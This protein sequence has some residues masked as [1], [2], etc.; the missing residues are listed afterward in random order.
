[1]GATIQE[2]PRA[3]LTMCPVELRMMPRREAPEAEAP[4]YRLWAT[5]ARPPTAAP[6]RV[7]RAENIS[8]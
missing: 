2:R 8:S 7:M 1:M 5:D 4:G 3:L 6:T